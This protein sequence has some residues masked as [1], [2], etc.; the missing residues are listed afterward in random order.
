M[1]TRTRV[2]KYFE[3]FIPGEPVPQG[4]KVI[5]HGGGKTWLRDANAPKL[6]A[7]R[8]H[9]AEHMAG[10]DI[11]MDGMLAVAMTFYMPKPK[12]P[13]YERPA[14]KPDLDK[15]AR[16][17][18]DGLTVAGI[19]ADDAR[20]VSMNLDEY[21]AGLHAPGVFVSVEKL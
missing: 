5:A 16:A 6:K 12:R 21:Y 10:R 13:Q 3:T 14:V 4:S 8:D 7:W 19:I 17:V 18:N 9:I 15:L 20:I 11:H 1:E 2:V